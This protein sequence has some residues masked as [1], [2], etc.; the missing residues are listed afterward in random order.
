MHPLRLDCGPILTGVTN[1]QLPAHRSAPHSLALSHVDPKSPAHTNSPT[2][3][4]THRPLQVVDVPKIRSA[5]EELTADKVRVFWS[6]HSHDQAAAEAAEVPAATNGA[7]NGATTPADP[8]LPPP[9]FSVEPYFNVKY[10]DEELPQDWLEA[11]RNPP[12][13]EEL[14]LPDSNDFI[15]TEFDLVEG[16]VSKEVPTKVVEEEGL[17]IWHSAHVALKVP[18]AVASFSIRCGRHFGV[19]WVAW[20]SAEWF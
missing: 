17:Q 11:F 20:G 19:V 18:K 14:R 9:T 12:K 10:A 3:P 13:V 6:S 2:D 5:L 8:P 1:Q 4:P 15:S 7:T 16:D